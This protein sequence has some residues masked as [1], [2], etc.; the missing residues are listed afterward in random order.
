[1]TR[2]MN[3]LVKKT[4]MT[5]D[6]NGCEFRATLY[7]TRTGL[8]PVTVQWM[9]DDVYVADFG[10]SK[11]VATSLAELKRKVGEM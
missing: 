7:R 9:T 11:V 4:F 5:K 6:V 3:R 1:M 10:T 2:K 8:D